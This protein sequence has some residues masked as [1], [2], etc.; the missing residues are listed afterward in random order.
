MDVHFLTWARFAEM[1]PDGS[2]TVVGAANDLHVVPRLPW[3]YPQFY[4]VCRLILTKEEAS[5]VHTLQFTMISPENETFVQ[6]EE[7]VVD[8]REEF[9]VNREFLHA[10][11][12]LVLANLI[13]THEGYYRIQLRYDGEIVKEVAFRVEV[14]VKPADSPEGKEQWS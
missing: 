14:Q 6:S 5:L 2:L 9:P 3:R 13:L 12:M 1:L 7:V 11:S 4:I 10:H 8:Q